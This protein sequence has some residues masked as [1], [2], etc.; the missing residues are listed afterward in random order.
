MGHGWDYDKRRKRIK[1][2]KKR[3]LGRGKFSLREAERILFSYHPYFPKRYRIPKPNYIAFTGRGI[4]LIWLFEDVYLSE[5]NK[6]FILDMYHRLAERLVKLFEDINPDVSASKNLSIGLKLPDSF[7]YGRRVRYIQ[8]KKEKETFFGLYEKTKYA[9]RG[10][11]KDMEKRWKVWQ[12]LKECIVDVKGQKIL[13]ID[14]SG[15]GRVVGVSRRTLFRIF[16]EFKQIGLFKWWKIDR[17]RDEAGRFI[18]NVVEAEVS[19]LFFKF[20]EDYEIFCYFSRSAKK[21]EFNKGREGG[22]TQKQLKAH[23]RG[24]GE[25]SDDSIANQSSYIRSK[26]FWLKHLE[27]ARDRGRYI[28]ALCPIH[29][30]HEPSFAV[31]FNQDGSIIPYCFHERRGVRIGE[32]FLINNKEKEVDNHGKASKV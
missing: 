24:A 6:G 32:I 30:E 3:I 4:H 27:G 15:V 20:A 16:K 17:V 12:K 8:V 21:M 5:R 18:A 14:A 26:E 10:R 9:F 29:P 11:K 7:S 22:T 31:Y 23:L 25:L 2:I 28:S 19:P 1:K 13:R